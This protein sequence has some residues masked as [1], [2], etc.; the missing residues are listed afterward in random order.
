MEINIKNVAKAVKFS[1]KKEINVM[2]ER[3]QNDMTG[4]LTAKNISILIRSKFNLSIK[5]LESLSSTDFLKVAERYEKCLSEK[6]IPIYTLLE[7]KSGQF[8]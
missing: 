3:E 6:K 5:A 4:L 7:G 1:K 8:N 2:D